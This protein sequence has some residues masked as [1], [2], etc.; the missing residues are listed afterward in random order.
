MCLC[1]RPHRNSPD[2]ACSSNI[3]A[4]IKLLQIASIPEMEFP[5]CLI[6]LNILLLE[7]GNV[8]NLFE[9]G[10]ESSLCQRHSLFPDL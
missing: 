8:S 1:V 4:A 9:P 6:F 2:L 10:H 5:D 7:F 3:I